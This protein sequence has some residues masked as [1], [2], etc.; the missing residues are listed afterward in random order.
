MALFSSTQA[1][2]GLDIGTSSLK[3]V[4]LLDRKKRIELVTYASANIPNLLLNPAGE[5]DDSI[6][7]LASVITRMFDSAGVST[8]VVVAAL[9]S[10]IVFSTVLML[11]DIADADMDNAVHFAARDIVPDNLEDLVL[12]WSRVGKPPH[13]DGDES[14][15]E[16]KPAVPAMAATEKKEGAAAV[17]ANKTVPVFMTAAPKAIVTRYTKLIELLKLNLFALEV[18]TFP[19]VRSLLNAAQGTA[20]IVDI[21]NKVTTFHVIDSGTVRVS[22]SIDFGGENFTQA[23]MDAAK[24]S[25]DDAEELKVLHGLTGDSAPAVRLAMEKATDRLLQQAKQ[26][27]DLY[28]RKNA[29]PFSKTVLIGG[30]ANLKG[31]SEKW[32]STA[33]HT[34]T[35]GNPWKG[36]SYPVELE[37]R[38][39]DLGSTYAVAVGLAQRGFSSIY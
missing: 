13:M 11:P 12:G 28:T 25:Q 7:Q 9:P 1:V 14:A 38:L 24:V 32:A 21:G 17:V 15:E 4:E 6:R 37:K 33:G 29:R 8:D 23:I 10:S 27:I 16:E 31:L 34:V 26:I 2:V 30:G 20:M 3:L 35:I 19:L 39:Q 36:L 22:H 18:E 5:E